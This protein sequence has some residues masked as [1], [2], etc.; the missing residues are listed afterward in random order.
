MKRATF[1]VAFCALTASPAYAQQPDFVN[2]RIVSRAAQPDV[3]RAIAGIA[4]A[5]TDAAWI[6]YAIPAI[7]RNSTGRNDGW[8]ERCRLEQQRIDPATKEA[9][10]GPVH[11]EPAPT[12][13]VLVRVQSGQI[14]R[15]RALSG[16]CQVDAGGLQVFWLGDVSASQ[17]VDFLKTLV[18]DIDTRQRTEGALA[19][20][21]LHRDSAATAA[22]LEMA[23]TGAPRV[24]Q[25]AL[26]WIAQRAEAQ[27]AAIITQAID[28]DPDAE[29][30]KQAVFALSQLPRDEGIPILI[31]LAGSSTHP[32]VRKQ[33]MFWLGQSKDPRALKFFEDILR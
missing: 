12:A 27:A 14:G 4:L 2:A 7:V 31:K 3:Q 1:V 24:R 28:S 11:L 6:G 13:M 32:V 9:L 23:K 19:A 22:I 17:S 21:A 16:D 33:A 8:S 5:Q 29:V 20:I 25:R 15:V 26:F 18:A 30:K 10:R